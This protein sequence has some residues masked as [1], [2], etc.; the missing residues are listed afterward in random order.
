VY[1][2]GGVSVL[3]LL[4]PV[5]CVILIGEDGQEAAWLATVLV[6]MFLHRLL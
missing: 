2:N 6:N 4:R 3:A 5:A 1:V